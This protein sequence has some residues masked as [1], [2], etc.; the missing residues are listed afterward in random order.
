MFGNFDFG[1][2]QQNDYTP[3]NNGSVFDI[4]N[5]RNNLLK[6]SADLQ[7]KINTSVGGGIDHATNNVMNN[8]TTLKILE[9]VTRRSTEKKFGYFLTE[10]YFESL[11]LDEDFK[12]QNENKIKSFFITS[13]LESYGSISNLMEQCK[14]KSN[15][16]K[17]KVKESKECGKKMS[18]KC[19]KTLNEICGKK[20]VSEKCGSSLDEK[21]KNVCEKCG[22]K[23][24][25]KCGSKKVCEKCGSSLDEKC[26]N[27]S[28]QCGSSLDEKCKK[29]SE[30]CGNKD[31]SEFSVNDFLK[32]NEEEFVDYDK[33]SI[34]EIS[35]AVKDKVIQ[36][37]KDEKERQEENQNF[38]QS[39]KDARSEE[40]V[41]ES[42]L[43]LNGQEDFSLYKS[44]MMGQ[45]KSTIKNLKESSGVT[46]LYGTL[47]ESGDIKVNM[48]Y[49]MCDTLLEY[50]KLELL[51]TLKIEN[52]NGQKLRSM[53]NDYAYN[54]N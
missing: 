35:N 39:I 43:F 1:D 9:E 20:K 5:E 47:S 21:C 24:D 30:K 19:S 38:L 4:F 49:I 25:E 22:A 41:S 42:T 52:Y 36:V 11:L 14:N 51:N 2:M 26:K 17:N 45:Y 28:E 23:L 46:S 40:T 7:R 48:D 31:L 34:N 54:R 6:E 13:L 33:A 50:T 8:N 44:I 10:A 53:A 29:V 3:M 15:L 12:L 32:D 16:L 37:V 27:V 18:E